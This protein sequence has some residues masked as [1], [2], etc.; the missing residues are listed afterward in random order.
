MTASLFEL[1]GKVAIVTGGGRGL[2]RAMARG[3]AA[4]GAQAVLTK[5]IRDD[6]VTR[7]AHMG[8]VLQSALQDRL[9]QHPHVGDIR[10]RGL[11]RG[12]E[13]VEDRAEK[14]PFDPALGLAGKVKKAAFAAGL[15]CYPMSGTRDGRLGDHVLLAPPFI[16]SEA[17]IGELVDKL[18]SAIEASLPGTSG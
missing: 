12:V 3:L 4:A 2:G 18:C 13:L 7:A 8:E 15:I 5:L 9:G 16:I 14:R 11:F 1:E 17:Q 10:G 6:L